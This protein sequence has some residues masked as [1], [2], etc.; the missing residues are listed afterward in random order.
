MNSMDDVLECM[1]RF[2]DRLKSFDEE[3]AA[4]L[5]HMQELHDQ[6]D[7]LWRDETRRRYDA[8]YGPLREQL[9]RFRAQEAPDYILFLERKQQRLREYLYG[10]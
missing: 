4:S 7:A 6:V 2:T 1:T 8:E 9:I 3:L 10:G 5:R